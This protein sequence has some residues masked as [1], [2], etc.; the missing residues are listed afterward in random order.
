MNAENK[1]IIKI[2]TVY[3]NNI[4]KTAQSSDF[5]RDLNEVYS[6]KYFDRRLLRKTN[7]TKDKYFNAHSSNNTNVI[8]NNSLI[9]NWGFS[10][11][12]DHPSART[13][14]DTGA[15]PEILKE[16]LERCKIYPE[17]IDIMII[18]HKYSDNKGGAMWLL[19]QNPKIV[20]Y[21]PKTIH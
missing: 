17:E 10:C 20:V 9:A 13:I 19:K 4:F 3:H 16:N 11:F 18:S 8:K 15:K 21:L 7:I 2:A 12:I 1:K 5:C 14:F 6:D